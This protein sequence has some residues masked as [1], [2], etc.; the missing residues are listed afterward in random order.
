MNRT[1]YLHLF[2]TLFVTIIILIVQHYMFIDSHIFTKLILLGI[3][4]FPLYF[5]VFYVL[6]YTVN[7]NQT[8]L[9]LYWG[10]L[11]LDGIWSYTYL[12][13]GDLDRKR[14][15]GVWK[16]SQDIYGTRVEGFGLTDT[17]QIRSRVKSVVDMRRNGDN[18]ELINMRFDTIQVERDN[19]SITSISFDDGGIGLFGIPTQFKSRTTIL[20]GK[21]EKDIHIDTF[22]KH[23]GVHS[24][25]EV[26]EILQKQ[27]P[28]AE[29]I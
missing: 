14:Y 18:Y 16:F 22:N 27:Y 11:Y 23:L 19:Y 7:R 15:F 3:L 24:E 6:R 28:L 12:K 1:P 4:S 25:E 13:E 26:L 20:G 8:L 2:V 10:K 21:L 17:F 29:D 5:V 9:R